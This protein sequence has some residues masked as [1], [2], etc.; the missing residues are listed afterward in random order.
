[1]YITEYIE[2]RTPS[3]MGQAWSRD[4]AWGLR[5]IQPMRARG[6]ERS[7]E[8]ERER[9]I[10]IDRVAW[11]I[12]N[13]NTN[14]DISDPPVKFVIHPPKDLPVQHPPVNTIVNIDTTITI[15]TFGNAE[16]ANNAHD[17][18]SNE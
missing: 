16:I 13:F 6:G 3:S 11:M 14:I 12:T 1:M 8:R 5:E 15:A 2:N 17:C 7:R 18:Y 10:S 9:E 4:D